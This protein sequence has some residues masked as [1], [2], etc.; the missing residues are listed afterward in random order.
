MNKL[1]VSLIILLTF[2][3]QS[4][5]FAQSSNYQV[6][7][8]I[9]L[10]GDG[11]WDY[12]TFNNG[13]LYISHSTVVQVYDIKEKKL[14][15]TIPETRGVHGIAIAN[16]LNK[17]FT[18]N[19]KDTS[20][21]VFDLKTLNVLTKIKITGLNPDAILYDSFSQRVFVFNGKT[22]NAT[23]IDAKTNQVISTIAFNGKP[24]FS[25]TDE[26][27]KV[28]VNIEDKNSIVVINSST[29]NIEH[30]WSISPGE[31]P[32]G[33]AIDNKTHR[34]FSVCGNKW[35]MILNSENGEVLFSFSIGDH[36]DGVVFDPSLN[37]IYASNGEGTMNVF[38]EVN[39]NSFKGVAIV[40]TQKGAKTI[41]LDNTTNHLYLPT[42]EYE[43][44]PE[45]SKEN[46]KPKA[47]IK[48]GT[49]VILDIA[50]INK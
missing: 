43:A 14:V 8:K 23:V 17:G 1:N 15:A 9:H 11:S 21:T 4:T 18:S 16:D 46:P 50:P 13:R 25:V 40:T 30:T 12:I 2:F 3:S 44:T 10:K 37:C 19:G 32:T 26:K 33:L 47:K 39:A 41:T 5:L 27:G 48:P 24:E 20:V 35:M 36:C 49:F 31:E 28:Y 29:L 45:P 38:K 42:A 6:V 22:N 34:L 7:N